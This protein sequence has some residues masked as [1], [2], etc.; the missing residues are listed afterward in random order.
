MV[1]ALIN[2]GCEKLKY[3]RGE[4]IELAEK[5]DCALPDEEAS[6]LVC[7]A[8]ALQIIA[9]GDI[10]VHATTMQADSIW[11]LNILPKL[12]VLP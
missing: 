7:T 3:S 10:E 4:V 11:V 9:A 12:K 1:D 8:L 5:V 2:L 6:P